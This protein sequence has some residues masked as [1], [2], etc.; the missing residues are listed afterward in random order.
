M[1]LGPEDDISA[2]FLNERLASPIQLG[3][4]RLRKA[5]HVGLLP[6]LI[7]VRLA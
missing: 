4:D 3:S 5:E 1:T 2:S 7:R 6:L